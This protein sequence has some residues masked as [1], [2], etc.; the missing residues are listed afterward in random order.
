MI[1]G[2]GFGDFNYRSYSHSLS[3]YYRRVHREFVAWHKDNTGRFPADWLQTSETRLA[4]IAQLAEQHLD[5]GVC[6]FRKL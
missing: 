1:Q 4:Q 3:T 2:A 5:W 6:S